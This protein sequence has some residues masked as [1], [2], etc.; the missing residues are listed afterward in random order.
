MR[1]ERFEDLG[2]WKEA[3]E[4]SIRIFQITLIE[5]FVKNF[6]FWD[7]IRGASGSKMDDISEGFNRGG[8][9]EFIQFLF[10][11]KGSAADTK[12][13]VYRTFDM[14]YINA[15]A[16]KEILERTEPLSKKIGSHIQHLKTYS[17]KSYKFENPE[18]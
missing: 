10:I 6:R 16:H 13:L 14:K 3:M 12:S 18:P 5:P 4:L 1:I 15:D 9:R 7:Q 8:N 17:Y 11:A 2:I